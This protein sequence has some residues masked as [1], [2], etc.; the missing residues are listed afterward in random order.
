MTLH[1]VRCTQAS[2]L[3]GGLGVELLKLANIFRIRKTKEE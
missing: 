3:F 1:E 2:G